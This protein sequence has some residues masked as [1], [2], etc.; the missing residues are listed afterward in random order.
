MP[1]FGSRS[2]SNLSEC[3]PDLQVLFGEVIEHFDCAVIEGRRGQE[4][5]DRLFDAGKSKLKFPRSMHNKSPSMAADVV[6]Y[7]IDWNDHRRFYLFG[8]FVLGVAAKLLDTGDMTHRVRY[9]GDWDM[10]FSISDQTF[11]DLP[12]FELVKPH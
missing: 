3:H 6:P 2:L 4:E 10:D 9:G 11:H 5:Q 12:H 1:K 8:G 7:P